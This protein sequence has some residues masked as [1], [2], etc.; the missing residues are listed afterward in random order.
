MMVID[1]VYYDST[2]LEGHSHIFTHSSQVVKSK[3]EVLSAHTMEKI[4]LN[5]SS[6]MEDA[7]IISNKDVETRKCKG[8]KGK[9]H[10]ASLVVGQDISLTE[11][12]NYLSLALVGRFCGKTIDE[13]ALRRWMEENWSPH[14]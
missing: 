6:M 7:V 1:E 8:S 14:L 11:I 3:K 10:A 5:L 13:A 4:R 12:P 2:T 9:K